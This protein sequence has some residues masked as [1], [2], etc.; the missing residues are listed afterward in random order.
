MRKRPLAVLTAIGLGGSLAVAGFIT[1]PALAADAGH[2]DIRVELDL[3]YEDGSPYSS[4]P[5]VF[6]VVNAPIGDGPELTAANLIGNP[7]GWC[8]SLQVDVD[9]AT[10]TI[11]VSP[12][13]VCNFTDVRVWVSSPDFTSMTLVSDELLWPEGDECEGEECGCEGEECEGPT[14]PTGPTET[15]VAF[16]GGG[17]SGTLHSAAGF[18]LPMAAPG[19]LA[20]LAWGFTAP[21][22]TASWR[23][24]QT[25]LGT[26]SVRTEDIAGSTVFSYA[27][28]PT[29]PAQVQTMAPTVDGTATTIGFAAI[30]IIGVGAIVVAAALVSRRRES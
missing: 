19:S 16:H 18:V 5:A 13:H 3:V 21:Q 9:P 8:G 25:G 2:V 17:G 7:S 11:T 14:G 10:Q 27:Q 20:T 24:D 28:S 29:P 15:P 1:T 22:L 26:E 12:D 6:E 30:A 4:G 23:V